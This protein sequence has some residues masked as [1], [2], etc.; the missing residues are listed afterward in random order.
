MPIIYNQKL[1]I[2]KLLLSMFTLISIL[3]LYG[4]SKQEADVSVNLPATPVLTIQAQWGVVNAPYLR[5]R[6]EPN[7][8][9]GVVDHLRI[10]S[11][12]EILSK[13]EQIE[14]I[15]DENDYWYEIYSNGVRGWVFGAYLEFFDSVEKAR[16]SAGQYK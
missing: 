14:T 15:E 16:T 9:G 1:L 6:K 10:G 13:T 3:L 7:I 5:V 4:C 11:L 12:A 8:D 2:K